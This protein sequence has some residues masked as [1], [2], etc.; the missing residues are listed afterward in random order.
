MVIEETIKE[1]EKTAA[2]TLFAGSIICRFPKNTVGRIGAICTPLPRIC[3]R[4]LASLWRGRAGLP[5]IAIPRSKLE[6]GRHRP[7][8]G[9]TEAERR[10]DRML[11]ARSLLGPVG[12]SRERNAG[13][14]HY[15]GVASFQ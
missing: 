1:L 8:S 4:A 2:C 7:A 10:A 9:L 13:E 6:S 11:A 12:G 15:S 5:R 14:P 3:D